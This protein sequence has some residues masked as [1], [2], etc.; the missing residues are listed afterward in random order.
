MGK[1]LPRTICG[2]RMERRHIAAVG[3]W[4]YAISTDRYLYLL[5]NDKKNPNTWGLPGGKVDKPE[6]LLE[7]LKRECQEELN[8]WPEPIKLAPIEQFTSP[9]NH[10]TFHTFLSL[11]KSEFF[12][13]LNN[14]HHGYA[15]IDSGH[16]PTPMHPGL[17]STTRIETVKYKVDTLKDFYKSQ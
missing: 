12:P 8:Y 9:D 1:K 16:L 7:A 11:I 17:W 14:E 6:T 2:R 10:F 15:W 3:V 5:R 4:F 13:I